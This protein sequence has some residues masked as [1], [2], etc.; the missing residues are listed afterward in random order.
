M[1]GYKPRREKKRGRFTVHVKGLNLE[2]HRNPHVGVC[3][4]TCIKY[5]N[6]MNLW[7]GMIKRAEI[8]MGLELR[9][10]LILF[11]GL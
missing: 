2:A 4:T 3:V 1:V 6:A 10:L 11:R 5:V 9:L 8:E 7:N